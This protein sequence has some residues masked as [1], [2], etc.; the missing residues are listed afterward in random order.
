MK[1]SAFEPWS[2]ESAFYAVSGG[3][4]VESEAFYP[5]SKITFTPQGLLEL[6]KAG[7]LPRVDEEA[8]HDKNKADVFAKFIACLQAIWF[9]A[10]AIARLCQ[11]LP[12]TLLELHTM[13]H[14]VCALC[15]YAI[16]FKKP[17]DVSGPTV[18]VDSR[19]VDMAALFAAG[20]ASS[21]NLLAEWDYERQT[22]SHR[23]MLCA[24]HIENGH[25][26]C[27]G[28]WS[29]CTWVVCIIARP[30]F[31]QLRNNHIHPDKMK[32]QEHLQ[33]ANRAIQRS[34]DRGMHI[35]WEELDPSRRPARSVYHSKAINFEGNTYTVG[36]GM[37][38]LRTR[39]RLKFSRYVPILTF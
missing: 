38:N 6:A 37:S 18:F 8:I 10:Q 31:V 3:F 36:G 27:Y 14:I 39:G 15:M 17:Y 34:R 33:K 1:E 16:W 12:I 11:N 32:V 21:F 20:D 23:D 24:E 4:C 35:L 26:S 22:C 28:P 9:F 2:L 19:I 7:I 5:C 30:D 25:R 13:T 29:L